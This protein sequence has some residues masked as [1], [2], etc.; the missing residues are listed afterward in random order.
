ILLLFKSILPSSGTPTSSSPACQARRACK[1]RVGCEAR[2]AVA[3]DALRADPA[4]LGSRGLKFKVS[5]VPAASKVFRIC[6]GPRRGAEVEEAVKAPEAGEAAGG[7][8][9]GYREHLSM[10]TP[11]R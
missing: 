11:R 10:L 4:A 2:E 8:S 6:R 1:A 9:P 3:A 5:A 7:A